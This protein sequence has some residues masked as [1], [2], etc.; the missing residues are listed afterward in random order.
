MATGGG[1]TSPGVPCCS[2][3]CERR[4]AGPHADSLHRCPGRAGRLLDADG[5]TW[6]DMPVVEEIE[7]VS[8]VS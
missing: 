1:W 7:R 3:L 5:R 8:G 4:Y 2:C 6:D